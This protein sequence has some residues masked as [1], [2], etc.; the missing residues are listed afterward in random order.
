MTKGGTQR[1]GGMFAGLAEALG[2]LFRS[3]HKIDRFEV[4]FPEDK[5]KKTKARS[6]N[7]QFGRVKSCYGG[8]PRGPGGPP[9]FGIDGPKGVPWRIKYVRRCPVCGGDMTDAPTV[10]RSAAPHLF[11][12][13]E[14]CPPGIGFV[15]FVGAV[16][17][18]PVRI[19]DF[20]IAIPADASQEVRDVLTQLAGSRDLPFTELRIA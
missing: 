11:L 10:M 14:T 20:A 6:R 17:S 13:C 2:G 15:P 8:F 16:R 4:P 12:K 7:K 18:I 1:R 3:G 19:Q 9:G 5:R